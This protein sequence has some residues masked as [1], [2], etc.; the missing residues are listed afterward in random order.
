MHADAVP[1]KRGPKTEV[2]EELLK[3]IDGLEKRLVESEGGG[4]R[5]PASSSSPPVRRGSESADVEMRDDDSSQ[6]GSQTSQGPRRIHQRTIS[7]PPV[8]SP[9]IAGVQRARAD[10]TS[11]VGAMQM[12]ADP[13]LSPKLVDVFFRRI[14]GKPYT[15]FHEPTFRNELA[16]GT[17]P[18]AVANAVCAA[19]VRYGVGT[20][21]RVWC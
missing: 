18:M 16:A 2:L 10:S 19:A 6:P 5:D 3:R 7:T 21:D 14:N 20:V 13:D 1:K 9:T 15:F 8:M 12:Q 4:G 11:T 17:L